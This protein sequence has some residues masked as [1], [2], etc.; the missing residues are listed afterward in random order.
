MT[1]QEL[2]G[3]V[4]P[5]PWDRDLSSQPMVKQRVK[6]IAADIFHRI[7]TGEYQFGTRLPAERELAEAFGESRTTIR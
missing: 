5:A 1:D 3:L 6:S 4:E 2:E 7:A